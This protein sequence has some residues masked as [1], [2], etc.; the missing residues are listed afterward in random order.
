VVPVSWYVVLGAA[1]F[2]IGTLGFLTRRNIIIMLISV[3][4]MLNGVNITLAAFNHYLQDMWGQVFVLFVIA[5]A[6]AEVAVGLAL[7]ITLFRSRETVDMDRVDAM[8]W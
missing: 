2:S 3:E 8:K 7:L 6:A 4:L 1:V 5:A